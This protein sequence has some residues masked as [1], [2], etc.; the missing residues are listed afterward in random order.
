MN[1]NLKNINDAEL[2]HSPNSLENVLAARETN[3]LRDS[4]M[5]MLPQATVGGRL[6]VGYT[7][8]YPGCRTSGHRHADREEVY[9][10]VKGQGRVEIG[11]KAFDVKPGDTFYVEPGL[12]HMLHNPHK[13]AVEYFWVTAQLDEQPHA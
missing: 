4:F 11:D 9:F 1:Y 13:E 12:F 7:V 5:L 10:I 8:V 3:V 2:D 6:T